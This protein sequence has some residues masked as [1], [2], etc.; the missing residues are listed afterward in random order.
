L[1]AP[2]ATASA[3][4][5]A[6]PVSGSLADFGA[7]PIVVYA[8]TQDFVAAINSTLRNAGLAAHCA[9]VREVK[10]LADSLKDNSSELLLAFV[11]PDAAEQTSILQIRK[12][13]AP[14]VP[15][16]LLRERID[17]DIIATA[18]QQGARDVV[19]LAS[20]GRLQA[21]VERELRAFRT[22]REL[23]NSR[24]SARASHE[25]VRAMMSGA[26]DAIAFVQEGIIVEAN[27]AWLHLFGHTE[28][29]TAVGNPL[30]DSLQ[31]QAH[32]AFKTALAECLRGKG[33]SQLRAQAVIPSQPNAAFDFSL[34]RA[35]H[36]GEPAVRVTIALKR[37]D[38]AVAPA[39]EKAPQKAVEKPLE[40]PSKP[41]DLTTG[42]L[43]RRS[44]I[45]QLKTQ[46]ANPLKSGVRQIVFVEIDKLPAIADQVGPVAIDD[47]LAQFSTVARDNLKGEDLA[48]CFGDGAIAILA[49]R[50]TTR[51]TEA[52]AKG[53]LARIAAH[54]FHVADKSVICT[55][56][57]G[58]GMVDLRAQD[59]GQPLTDALQACREA[60]SQ[61]GNRLHTIDRSDEDTKQQASDAI[62]I[63][64][65]KSALMDGR[66]KLMQQPIA[67]LTGGERGMFDVLVRMVDEQGGDV[68]PSEFM[69][70]AARNDLMKS[71]D[72]WI[73]NSALTLS[74][75]RAGQ[76]LFVR[77]S[78]DSVRDRTLMQ[79]LTLQ[80]N[81]TRADPS[82][83][84]FQVS[85]QTAA[86]YLADTSALANAV[87]QAGFKFALEHFGSGRE[88]ARLLTHLTT[89]YLKIDGTLM[90]NLAV[91]TALQ[92]RVKD[93][94]DGAKARK[95][96]TIAE[97]VE[98]A[99]TMAILW[100]LGV[101]YIQGYF[102][103]EPEQVTLGA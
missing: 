73:L 41:I 29:D 91:D 2:T 8:R 97:R 78:Q 6:A 42:L 99:N 28:A 56:S 60:R 87:R 12:Q 62:W 58:I 31:P 36:D 54:V 11:G 100:Q 81:T 43:Q 21:V 23:A 96:A 47:F 101:E 55:C 84:A 13:A 27:P 79:W 75:G 32:A 45:E 68:L 57:I 74:A 70:A 35:E 69:A 16:I 90:Q 20:R 53:F 50:P 49:E 19:T 40:R 64:M 14:E 7:T 103:N 30:M 48:G 92:Q 34:A 37:S 44:F 39:Q 80:L 72:R 4:Q 77:L 38:D 9:W 93:L 5:P 98:D 71:I 52:W 63:K 25:Q 46:V 22:A 24:T 76:R 86:E 89:D 66:F 17:E 95:I 82:R 1:P 15:A 3:P 10:D 65:I 102:V 85:E 83:I 33:N 51:D 94:V 61:G 18:M 67:S 59:I 88:S 26:A